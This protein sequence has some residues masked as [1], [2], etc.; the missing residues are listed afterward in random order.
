MPKVVGVVQARMGSSRLPGKAL[1]QLGGKPLVWHIVDRMHRADRCE[2]IVLAT[3]TDPRNGPL[4]EYAE[5]LGLDVVLDEIEDDLASRIA[6]AVRASGADYVLKTGGDCPLVDPQVMAGMV[7][8]ALQTKSDFCSNRVRWSFPLGLSCDVVSSKAV[9]WCDQNLR[10]P[11][12]RE[13][14]A[15]YI[16]DHPNQFVVSSFE[17]NVDLSDL[18]WTVDTPEDFVA[19]S[20]IFDALFRE[21][22]CFGLNDVL[23]Y[24]GDYRAVS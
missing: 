9:L 3:T 11:E 21:G 8:L 20:R 16:R 14:F 22:E 6:R 24:L 19:V 13:L 15:L 5:E 10:K 4:I 17:R 7:D 12:D 23:R 18:S 1:R 2:A